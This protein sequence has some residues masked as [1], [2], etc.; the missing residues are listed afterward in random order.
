MLLHDVVTI[1]A[2]VGSTRSRRAKMDLIAGLLAVANPGEARLAASYLAGTLPQGRIGVGWATI[3]AIE[4]APAPGGSLT[5][6]DVDE[7]LDRAMETAGPGSEAARRQIVADLLARATAKEQD[8]LVALLLGEVR[9]GALEGAVVD[10]VASCARVSGAEVRR[11]LM[12]G[13]D[14]GEVAAGAIGGGRESLQE[15]RLTLFRPVQPML[16]GSAPDPTAALDKTGPAAVE[17]KYDGARIQVHRDGNRVAVYTRNLREITDRVPEIVEQ[18]RVVEAGSLILDGEAIVLDDDG[19]PRPFQETAGRFGTGAAAASVSLTP[20]FFDLLH[21][22]G[23]DLTGNSA[24]ERH[25]AMAGVLPVELIVPRIRTADPTEAGA[26]FEAAIDAGHEGVVV[27]SL[28]SGYEAGR[29]G[30]AW[31]KVKPVHTLDLVVLAAE[32]GYG[33]R[34]GLL[35]NIHLGARDPAGGGFVMLGKTFKGLTDEI[36]S[37]QTRRFLTLETGRDRNTVEVRPEQVV[38][39]AFDGVQSSDRYPGGVALRFARVRGY[40]D[41][42]TADEADTID[43][44]LAI[45]R[46]EVRPHLSQ[47]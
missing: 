37:W 1:S 30:A 32:W 5:L 20:V 39:V 16:A 42:K 45:H 26:F 33:R 28:D 2:A 9:Q 8:Y 4:A 34:R 29:R 22:D 31:V 36:L 43:T 14:L 11:A 3:R 21:L 7:A 12:V 46:G 15:F 6:A 35:S 17:Y 27:K 38:E 10:A 24:I 13:G 18:V 40:R 44:V 19:R 47:K 25:D 41:D 23:A